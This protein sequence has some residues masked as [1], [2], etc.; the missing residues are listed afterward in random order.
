MTT[1]LLPSL[2]LDLKRAFSSYMV[3]LS[4]PGI[5]DPTGAFQASY[6]YLAALLHASG[7]EGFLHRLD[8]ETTHLAGQVHQ[9]LRHR[10][11][12]SDIDIDYLEVEDR[13]RECFEYAL[14]QLDALLTR[15]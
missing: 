12:D 11:R 7:V 14:G 1:R 13:L 2:R 6:D 4:S 15:P 10:L 9:D 3:A 5:A 8:D